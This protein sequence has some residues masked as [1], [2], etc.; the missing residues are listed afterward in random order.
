MKSW[1]KKEL[2]KERDW[3]FVLAVVLGSLGMF[4]FIVWLMGQLV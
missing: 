2:H 4:T 3:T 1:L